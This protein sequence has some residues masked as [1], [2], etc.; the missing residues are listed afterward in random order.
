MWPDLVVGLEPRLGDLAHL[1]EIVEEIRIQHFVAV[2]PIEAFD[3]RVLIG[4]PRLNVPKLDIVA[5]TPV[6][7][8]LG[9][10]LRAVV[11]AN[12]QR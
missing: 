7:E 9:D 2:G 12:G 5:V 11:Q 3:V 8:L 6:G 1:L 10:E 4:F